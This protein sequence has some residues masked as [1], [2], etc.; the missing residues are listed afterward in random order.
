MAE[1]AQETECLHC[2]LTKVIEDYIERHG[3]NADMADTTAMIVEALSQ[4]LREAVPDEDRSDMVAHALEHL[5]VTLRSA[6][7]GETRH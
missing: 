4:F 5:G 7:E 2:E 3:E 1:P 6:R